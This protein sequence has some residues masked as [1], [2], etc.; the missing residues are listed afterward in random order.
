MPSKRNRGQVIHPGGSAGYNPDN[1]PF[2]GSTFYGK[3][4]KKAKKHPFKKPKKTS[5]PRTDWGIAQSG[6]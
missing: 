2:S 1:Q 3:G 4:A 5:D 6:G